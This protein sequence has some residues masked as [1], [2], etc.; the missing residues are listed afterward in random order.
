M[1]YTIKGAAGPETAFVITRLV[2]PAPPIT[3]LPM[4]QPPA[5]QTDFEPQAKR[6]RIEGGALTKSMELISACLAELSK[7]ERLGPSFT[8][9]AGGSATGLT[10]SNGV[11]DP[12]DVE[13]DLRYALCIDG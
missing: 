13:T 12:M 7:A 4:R 1:S 8:L 10:S 3:P 9:A 11:R 6:R 5:R 2:A